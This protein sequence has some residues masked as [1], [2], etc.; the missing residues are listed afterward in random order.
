MKT[1]MSWS[2]IWWAFCLADV[3][4][5]H[6]QFAVID[7]GAITQL[8]EEIRVLEEQ[9]VTARQHLAEAQAEYVSIT[10]GRGM[11]QLLSGIERNY[12]PATWP[13]L[14]GV[15]QG[16]G[17]LYGALAGEVAASVAAN[18]VL[19]PQQVS[20]LPA[21]SRQQL[22]VARR[23]TALQQAL[24]REALST[25]SER[26]A[27]LQGLVNAIG[28]ATDQKAILD[29]QARIGA[30]TTLLQNE[31]SKLAT[32]FRLVH[33]EEHANQQRTRELALAGHG[34]FATRF[35]PVP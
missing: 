9:L 4:L 6:A 28:G 23:L 17:G 24:T 13:Q 5:A 15:M 30:E 33:A 1:R 18:T 25:T 14:Q 3:P 22:A 32:L 12:L 34:D 10:G 7:V 27:T 11:E 8:V 35:Q 21:D 20:L 29:L 16:G 26:F 19:T 31:Q 2:L